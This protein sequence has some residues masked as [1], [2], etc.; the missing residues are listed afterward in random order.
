MVTETLASVADVQSW[1]GE[2]PLLSATIRLTKE[3]DARCPYCYSSSF[4]RL[5]NELNREEVIDVVDQ[6]VS[7]GAIR[8]FLSGGE[9]TRVPHLSDVVRRASAGGLRVAVSTHG[10][11]LDRGLIGELGAAGLSQLQVSIDAPGELHDRVRGIPGL[12]G[13][14]L[15]AVSEAAEILPAPVD[16]IVATVVT[17]MNL[18]SVPELFADV[19]S[20]GARM[21]TLVPL[22]VT[23]R[24][25]SDLSVDVPELLELV[26]RLAPQ[27]DRGTRLTVLLPPALVPAATGSRVTGYVHAQ[28]F[29]IAVDANGDVALSDL[30]LN[31]PRRLIGNVRQNPIAAMYRDAVQSVATTIPREQTSVSGVCAR[32]RYWDVC[33]GGNRVL[34]QSKTGVT[35]ASDPFC[36]SAF[37]AGCFPA[38]ALLP[39]MEERA[40]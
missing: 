1:F 32:C 8:L 30:H 11:S 35:D 10:G 37:D 9:P 19:R 24:A 40:S 39:E 17:T 18:G 28:P 29:E 34:A 33:G 38:S 31:P 26:R 3:C 20:A 15:R 4:R 13:R 6:I 12:Y 23:G 16:V 21:F 36:Q 2:L 27:G 22:V 5:P 25:R 14:A 7:L